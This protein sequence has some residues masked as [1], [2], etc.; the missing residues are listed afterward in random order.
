M[1]ISTRSDLLSAIDD[2]TDRSYSESR[3]DIWIGNAEA[4]FNRHLLSTF[5]RKSDT[6]LTTNSSGEVS[7]PSGF[8]GL[9]SI[10][11]DVAGSVPLSQ[12]SWGALIALNPYE[13]ESDPTHYA[14]KGTTL[15]VAP[16]V[17]D[18]FTAVFES[19][20]SALSP[21]NTTNWLLTLA[22]DAYLTMC[23]A[24]E[25]L[26]TRDFAAASG[27]Q[28]SA[29][30]MINDLVAMDQVAA[31]GNVEAQPETVMP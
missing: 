12:V 25:A 15:K 14:I 5:R 22:P 21:S 20:L 2:Y 10:V 13:T 28:G 1:A 9:T 7:L 4:K 29:I 18:S 6:T 16:I 3:K 30:G 27:L 31:Y 19:T 8:A 17:E 24:E 23:L 11:R 26:F